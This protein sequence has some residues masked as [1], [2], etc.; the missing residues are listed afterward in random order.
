[1]PDQPLILASA[2]GSAPAQYID[3]LEHTG[4]AGSVAAEEVITL[5]VEI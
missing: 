5:G 3:R 4:F 2:E 1:M